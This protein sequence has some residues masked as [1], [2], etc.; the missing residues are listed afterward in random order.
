MARLVSDHSHRLTETTVK[1]IA[2][3]IGREPTIVWVIFRNVDLS[4]GIMNNYNYLQLS[5]INLFFIVFV[6]VGADP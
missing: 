2:Q 5:V 6:V 3:I 4:Q 1:L